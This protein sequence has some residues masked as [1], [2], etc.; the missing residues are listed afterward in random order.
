MV[1]GWRHCLFI[2]FWLAWPASAQEEFDPAPERS[3]YQRIVVA[4][5]GADDD[6]RAAYAEA[7]LSFLAEIYL[8]EA[9]LAR[10]QATAQETD[11]KLLGWSRGVEQYAN[12]LLLV[13][14]DIAL[15][16]PAEVYPEP[17]GPPRLVVGGRSV[18]LN[19][20]REDQQLVY[21]QTV[22]NEFCRR[23]DCVALLP[24]E[25]ASAAI[26]MSAPTIS[27]QWRFAASGPI[28]SGSGIA[29]QF[30]ASA[31]L[32]RIKPLCRQ[33]L[34]EL[35]AL[36]NDIRWQQRHGVVI[37]WDTVAIVP[38]PQRPEH[39]V[40]LN[41]V[42]D[43]T[44]LSLPVLHTSGGLLAAVTPWLAA[45]AGGPVESLELAAQDYGWQ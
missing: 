5:H 6:W 32:S 18:I 14:E 44:L 4:L 12:Q 36:R 25:P 38:T 10:A 3:R 7:A 21:E 23:R 30:A 24:A 11:P 42:G 29:V 8:A 2:C 40:L 34:Q 35:G 19:H 9:D 37:D 22:L 45:P 33:L 16:F 43:T 31:D 17:L 41:N 15:G 13:Q 27:P 39:L 28:C 20:P 26:P 1:C